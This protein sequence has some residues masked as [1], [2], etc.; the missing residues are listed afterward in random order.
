V[1]RSEDDPEVTADGGD[2][3]AAVDLFVQ[4]SRDS[5]DEGVAERVR[6]LFNSYIYAPLAIAWGDWR[7][8]AGG[9]ILLFYISLPTI[10]VHLTP[11]PEPFRHDFF[12]PP[13]A[14][15][16]FRISS[17]SVFG[18]SI[19]WPEITAMLGSNTQG[20]SLEALL[21]Y[22]SVPVFQM[23]ISGA[24]F[25]IF[26]GTFI[27]TFA[28]YKGGR[29]DGILMTITDVILTVPGLALIVVLAAFF[30][31]E[32]PYVVGLI[33]GIDNWPGLTRTIRSQVLSIR[34]ESY[35]EAHRA[36]GLDTGTILRRD[37]ISQLMPYISINFANSAR[38]IIFESVGL[39]FIGVLPFN[40]QNW[41]V[42]LNG[43]YDNISLTN[44]NQL[45]YL[46]EPMIMIAGL[47]FGLILFAQGLDKVFNVRLQAR[48]AEK[49]GESEGTAEIAE[50][51]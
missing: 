44:P 21:I 27:G 37:I 9:I 26:L 3:D 1:S 23:I 48:H 5:P 41:G 33:L 10:G 40:N 12:L 43:A 47:S 29:I 46:F 22:G 6:R 25:S 38:R 42:I 17:A 36:L 28:G 4:E 39:Y 13:F 24:L 15:G 31:P 18:V 11:A 34:E 30:R 51:M 14:D 19:P 35:I 50:E 49:G 45:Y 2:T 20:Q 16:W 32:N 7:T 8:R